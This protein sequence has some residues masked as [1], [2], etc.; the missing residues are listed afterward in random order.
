MSTLCCDDC[1]KLVKDSLMTWTYDNRQVCEECYYKHPRCMVCGEL[2]DPDTLYTK[3][4][5]TTICESCF[6]LE[7]AQYNSLIGR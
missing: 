4:D 6:D 1:G 7:A 2:V 3:A 5:G